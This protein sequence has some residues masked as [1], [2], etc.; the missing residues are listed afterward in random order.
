MNRFFPVED[1][2]PVAFPKVADIVPK[3]LEW[4]D[5]AVTGRVHFYSAREEQE[6]V[7]HPKRAT[8]RKVTDAALADQVAALAAQ[9]QPLSNQ[10]QE[11]LPFLCP[12]LFLVV[13]WWPVFQAWRQTW[14]Y[15]RPQQ[16][17]L[18]YWVI[19]AIPLQVCRHRSPTGSKLR[20]SS[21]NLP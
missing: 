14:G 16:K 3:V 10:H 9:V 21:R 1:S 17:H 7:P 11:I 4:C 13:L 12:N 2:M 6:R 15:L 8:P 5:A 19:S 20:L 18:R